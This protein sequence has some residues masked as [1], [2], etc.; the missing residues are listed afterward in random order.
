MIDYI[1]TEDNYQKFL[2]KIPNCWHVQ[3]LDRDKGTKTNEEKAKAIFSF[4][5]YLD[6]LTL[7][8]VEF[9]DEKTFGKRNLH[10]FSPKY[11]QKSI[12]KKIEEI[13][14]IDPKAEI[15]KEFQ[16]YKGV[17]S[18][19]IESKKQMKFEY[20]DLETNKKIVGSFNEALRNLQKNKPKDSPYHDLFRGAHKCC[21]IRNLSIKT[22]RKLILNCD[23]MI[24][25]IVPFLAYY[26]S[27]I[28]HLDNRSKKSF[29]K[30]IEK[31]KATDYLCALTTNNIIIKKYLSNLT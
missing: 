1:V 6:L 4:W 16:P 5:N 26:F 11:L 21:L 10:H 9:C 24:A 13:L 17:S 23:S 19:F 12:L 15:I 14:K 31:F 22:N 25:P 8:N 28:L 3:F 2:E 29:W 30:T 18:Y 27:E 20:L 7:E